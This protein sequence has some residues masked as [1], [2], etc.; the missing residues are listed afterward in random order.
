LARKPVFHGF[1][2]LRHAMASND[3]VTQELCSILGLSDKFGSL[4]QCSSGSL[5]TALTLEDGATALT[6]EDGATALTLEDA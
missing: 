1:S 6:L 5:G 3:A 4:V 2:A